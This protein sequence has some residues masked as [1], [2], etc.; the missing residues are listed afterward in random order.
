VKFLYDVG[1]VARPLKK[2]AEVSSRR[3]SLRTAV[4]RTLD[5]AA[6]FSRRFALSTWSSRSWRGD[7]ETM[8]LSPAVLAVYRGP[9]RAREPSTVMQLRAFCLKDGEVLGGSS[10]PEGKNG[11]CSAAVCAR[12]LEEREDDEKIDGD[13]WRWFMSGF[14]CG[15][16]QVSTRPSRPRDPLVACVIVTFTDVGAAGDSAGC[17]GRALGFSRVWSIQAM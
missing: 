17:S 4:L 15:A 7:V 6:T 5:D 3:N 2:F 11:A 12:A 1:D 8:P 10:R 16:N 14:S 9:L 13:G